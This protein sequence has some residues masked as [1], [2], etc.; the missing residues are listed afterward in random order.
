MVL[1]KPGNPGHIIRHRFKIPLFSLPAKMLMRSAQKLQWR[2]YVTSR[3]VTNNNDAAH[4]AIC[5]RSLRHWRVCRWRNRL[6][7]SLWGLIHCLFILFLAKIWRKLKDA[8]K[9]TGE[10]EGHESELSQD[11]VKKRKKVISDY[12]PHSVEICYIIISLS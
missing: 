5:A 8:E 7:T 1:R 9:K 3:H 2:W 10:Q 12:F 6:H 11:K 4:I